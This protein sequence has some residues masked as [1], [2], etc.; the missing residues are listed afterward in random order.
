MG[1][2]PIPASAASASP[3]SSVARRRPAP[4]ELKARL[5]DLAAEAMGWPAGEVRLENDRFVAG[6]ESAPFEEVA[7][8]IVARRA[9]RA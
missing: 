2:R 5:E 8:A 9:G 4:T 3:T 7:A 6:E 1:R